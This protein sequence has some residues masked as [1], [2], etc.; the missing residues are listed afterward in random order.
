MDYI[1]K[2][3]YG[4]CRL[5]KSPLSLKKVLTL[6]RRVAHYCVI[7]HFKRYRHHYACGSEKHFVTISSN[8]EAVTLESLELLR[9]VSSLEVMH[10]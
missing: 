3:I 7:E 1:N 4:I 2:W 10:C 8:F 6:S 5:I 9:N